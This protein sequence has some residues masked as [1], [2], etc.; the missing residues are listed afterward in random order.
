MVEK[1]STSKIVD[2]IVA[3]TV[4]TILLLSAAVLVGVYVSGE[5]LGS[6]IWERHQN[7]FSWYSRPLFVIPACYYAYRRNLWLVAGFM[8]L[9][10]C[11]LFWFPAPANVPEHVERYLAW[12][13]QMFFSSQSAVPLFLLIIAVIVFLFLLFY[14]FWYRN[15]WMGLLLL[16]VGTLLKIVV[17]IRF[18]VEAG[19][20]AIVPSLSS[21]VVTN[22]MALVVWYRINRSGR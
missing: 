22:L 9:V 4:A 12:E 10:G 7:Q 6:W 8:V 14:A 15:P 21:L 17:S 5:Q 13:H 18:G 2:R 3:I 16:N 20:A 11:S 19:S 1:N